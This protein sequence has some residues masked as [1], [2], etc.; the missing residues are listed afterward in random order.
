M[1][2]YKKIYLSIFVSTALF[3]L[4]EEGQLIVPPETNINMPQNE[5]QNV[6]QNN[7]NR[8]EQQKVQQ[9]NN[10]QQDI[11]Q[12]LDDVNKKRIEYEEMKNKQK[13]EEKLN[14]KDY[15]LEQAKKDNEIYEEKLKKITNDE[16][17]KQKEKDIADLD[18]SNY[19]E[20]HDSIKAKLN[21]LR[22]IEKN[23]QNEYKVDGFFTLKILGDQ[24]TIVVPSVQLYEAIDKLILNKKDLDNVRNQIKFFEGSLNSTNKEFLKDVKTYEELYTKTDVPSLKSIATD[25]SRAEFKEGD[26][27]YQN[28]YI[29]NISKNSY[30]LV[31]KN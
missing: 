1:K 11:I 29:T 3:A 24:K 5:Q 23:F 14:D 6:E 13:E 30:T 21:T 31:M 12:L 9:N 26:S 17:F 4:P 15:V 10:S 7:L 22:D 27:V 8:N 25:V 16:K 28:I 18:K 19:E 20:Y 2:F